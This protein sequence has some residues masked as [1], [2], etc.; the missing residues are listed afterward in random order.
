[1][2]E[3][4]FTGENLDSIE[5][6]SAAIVANPDSAAAEVLALLANQS[7]L[8]EINK[9][10]SEELEKVTAAAPK[11]EEAK[12]LTLSSETFEK[13]GI[14]YGFVYPAVLLDGNKITA[15]DV[16]ADVELQA[17][18]IEMESGFLKVI[19]E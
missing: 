3:K 5:A 1:M 15:D 9:E 8:E 18:L 2:A 7:T 14:K 17:Q 16:L 4:I 19:A 13:D 11:V 6:L 12:V 10:L